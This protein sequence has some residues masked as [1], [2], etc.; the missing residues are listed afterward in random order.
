MREIQ[1]KTALWEKWIT[2]TVLADITTAE[3]PDPVEIVDDSG[4]E[5]T[6]TDAYDD[7][8]LGRG[9]GDYLYLLYLLDEP[10]ETASDIIPVYV[11]ETGSVANRLLDHFRRLC[12]A[13]PT[14]EWADDGSWG[15]YSKY[16]H[17]ATV[18]ERAESPLYVWVCDVDEIE[19]GPYG[20]PTY[21][22][23]LEAQLVGL[24]H[25]HP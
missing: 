13:L 24:A 17:I 20:Y 9:S 3:T 22:H 1:S 25:S 2:Q 11:G 5:L 8:R 10:V 21:R 4:A 16:D 7:Y 19:R 15:S 14:S 23:E 18:Y 6:K 12:D